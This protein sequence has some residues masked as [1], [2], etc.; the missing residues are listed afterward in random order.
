MRPGRPVMSVSRV[1]VPALSAGHHPFLRRGDSSSVLSAASATAEQEVV[2]DAPKPPAKK[3]K[4]LAEG[5]VQAWQLKRRQDSE[6]GIVESRDSRCSTLFGSTRGSRRAS[7]WRQ[8]TITCS[9]EEAPGLSSFWLHDTQVSLGSS[10][11]QLCPMLGEEGWPE[12]LDQGSQA[13]CRL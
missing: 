12:N 9:K 4:T 10:Q 6:G 8:E 2:D 5:E 13:D 7:S 3:Q 11:V 1:Y